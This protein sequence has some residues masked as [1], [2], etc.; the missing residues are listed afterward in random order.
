MLRI[1]MIAA[2]ALTASSAF[3]DETIIRH[4]DGPAAVETSHTHVEKHISPDGCAS[5]TVH[6]END[7]GDSKTIHKTNCD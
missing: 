3:A 1:M 6:K 4:D 2:F 7:Q 5:K